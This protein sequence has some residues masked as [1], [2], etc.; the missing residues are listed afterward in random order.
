MHSWSHDGG[1][2]G[3]DA[4][5]KGIVADGYPTVNVAVAHVDDMYDYECRCVIIRNIP[6]TRFSLQ[7]K[8]S[9]EEPEVAWNDKTRIIPNARPPQSTEFSKIQVVIRQWLI[10]IHLSKAFFKMIIPQYTRTIW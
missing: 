6:R 10:A 5:S 9:S 3:Y 8:P 7:M 1:H 4:A 2:D